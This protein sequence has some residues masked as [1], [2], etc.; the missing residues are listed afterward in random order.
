MGSDVYESYPMCISNGNSDLTRS[1]FVSWQ[2]ADTRTDA[3]DSDAQ[4]IKPQSA[5]VTTA[6]AAAI[7]WTSFPLF[8]EKLHALPSLLFPYRVIALH[9]FSSLVPSPYS[10]ISYAAVTNNSSGAAGRFLVPWKQFQLFFV[11]DSG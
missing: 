7:I 2:T 5:V 9:R 11:V 10:S 8:R 1:L 6:T 4:R 3:S